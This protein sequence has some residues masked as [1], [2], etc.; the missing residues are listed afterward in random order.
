MDPVLAS[1][2]D[3]HSPSLIAEDTEYMMEVH[4]W[5]SCTW[6]MP[7]LRLSGSHA[8]NSELTG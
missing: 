2:A 1:L 4:P 5:L 8:S 7:E 6:P 3:N